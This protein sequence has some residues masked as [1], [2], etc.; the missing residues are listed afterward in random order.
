MTK[1]RFEVI[2]EMLTKTPSS[3]RLYHVDCGISAYNSKD[4]AA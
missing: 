2:R 3:R 4:L 1:M